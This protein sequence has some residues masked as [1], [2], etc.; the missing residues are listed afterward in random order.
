MARVTV[1]ENA[2]TGEEITSGAP[3]YGL[4]QKVEYGEKDTKLVI[5]EIGGDR[6]A[7]LDL[8]T[9]VGGKVL[10]ELTPVVVSRFEVKDEPVAE[11]IFLNAGEQLTLSLGEEPTLTLH[12]HDGSTVNVPSETT[13]L[14][15]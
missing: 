10:I 1:I 12:H 11:G 6:E 15:D 9:L 4:L 2:V 3:I 8:S 7:I 13:Y 5:K 14:N